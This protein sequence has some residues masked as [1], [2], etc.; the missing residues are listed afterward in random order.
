MNIAGGLALSPDQYDRP[1]VRTHVQT[2]NVVTK[3]PLPVPAHHY[4]L[5]LSSGHD[6]SL[7]A[8]VRDHGAAQAI[9]YLTALADQALALV[10]KISADASAK[11]VAG[12]PDAA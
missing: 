3:E 10:T 12:A 2:T 7:T 4:T 6:L 1:G 11:E 8:L 5:E 9:K